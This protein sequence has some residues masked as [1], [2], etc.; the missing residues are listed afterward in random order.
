[1][2]I[3]LL[4]LCEH[5]S[6]HA[7]QLEWGKT[8]LSSAL[9]DKIAMNKHPFDIDLAM[10]RIREA[11]SPYPKAAMFQLF[12]EGFG[13]PFELL[14]ACIISVRTLDEV[15]LVCARRL[16]EFGRNPHQLNDLTPEQI[17][18]A[19]NQSTFHER[20]A[21]QIHALAHR[22]VTDHAGTLPCDKEI[23]VSFHG[24]GPKC[25]NLVLGIGCDQ[26]NIGVDVHV[27]RITNRW[28]YVHAKSAENTRR[29]LEEKL[30]EK[31]WVEINQVLVPFG[32][33]ICTGN[34]PRCSVCPLNDMCLQIG[35]GKCR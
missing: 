30:P 19:I 32:K 8:P 4:C 7:S 33:R 5:E 12:D 10:T 28:G 27:H 2:G 16:F 6:H 24:V 21:Q 14:V 22:L 20:K 34:Y 1:M 11:V 18:R 17:E 25:A 15:M 35:V 9:K 31:Y 13:T 29:A 23:L 3:A 26:P